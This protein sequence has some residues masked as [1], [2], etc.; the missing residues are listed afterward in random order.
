MLL[1][2]KA[3]ATSTAL[4]IREHVAAALAPVMEANR[5]LVERILV[6]EARASEGPD[7][8]LISSAVADAVAAL[9]PAEPGK[10]GNDF[11]PD[12]AELARMLDESVARHIAEIERPKDGTSVTID[13][14]QPL[15]KDA[16][17]T[18][19][20][21][22]PAPK[23]GESVNPDD[24]RKMVEV[25]VA[26][27][28]PAAPGK[29]ADPDLVRRIVN[30]AVAEIKLP[31]PRDPIEIDMDQVRDWISVEV[32]KMP[33]PA[34][35]KSV[36]TDEVAPMIQQ[37]V[38]RAVAA[39]PPA[40]DGVGLAGAL[41][42]RDG[43]L[44][45]TLTDGTVRS[46]GPVVGRDYDE[47][48]LSAAVTEAVAK[49]PAPKDG[50]PGKDADPALIQQLVEDA[51]AQIPL[52]ADGKD[53]Y[54]GQACGLHDPAAAYRALDIVSFNGSGWIAKVD[55]PGELPGDGWML[56]AQRGKPGKPGDPGKE[57]R[58]AS[59]V[60]AL[61]TDPKAMQ[62]ILTKDDGTEMK[63]DLA[64]FAQTIRSI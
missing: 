43:G 54:P 23:D 6:L 17:S 39:I 10:D 7:L 29:D 57:G 51:V 24:V 26:A 36:T 42:D 64:D 30:E 5:A 61:Y 40:Q 11:V 48:V 16:I 47:A 37:A 35:G 8:T 3:I 53:A 38:D 20:A 28:P 27:I 49:I 25:A 9:P 2:A 45:V 52:P 1:D 12:M 34:D 44:V 58:A 41:I 59:E 21:A 19:V 33:A 50:D 55:N 62:L 56:L 13:D 46:L 32:G 31:Q 22:I 60:V 15:I 63:A 4:I 18:A 14:V